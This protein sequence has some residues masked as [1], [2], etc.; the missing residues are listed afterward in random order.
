MSLSNNIQANARK[1]FELLQN[2]YI[3]DYFQREYKW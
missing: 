3:V 2:K 1:L